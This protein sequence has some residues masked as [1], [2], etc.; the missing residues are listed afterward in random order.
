MRL[1]PAIVACDQLRR[2]LQ[3]V[4]HMGETWRY[5][6]EEQIDKLEPGNIWDNM[7][8]IMIQTGM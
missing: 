8:Y 6:E 2:M 7:E 4:K 5:P 3:L 1:A